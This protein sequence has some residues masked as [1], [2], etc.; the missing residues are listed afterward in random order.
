MR[1]GVDATSWVNRRGYGRFARNVLPRLVALD[2]ET[3]YEFFVDAETA[4]GAGLPDGAGE[5]RIR[6]DRAPTQA[7]TAGSRRSLRDLARLSRAATAAGLDV[8]LFPSV[9]TY[10]PVRSTPTV[11]GIHDTIP[12][13]FPD[14]AVPGRG[15]RTL[16]RLKEWVAVRRAARL[17]TVSEPAR[18]ALARRL[19][20]DGGRIAVVPEAADDVFSPRTAAE[21]AAAAAR[22][23]LAAGERFVLYVGGISPHKDLG[24]LLRAYA[25]VAAGDEAPA[26]LVLAGELETEAYASAAADVRRE[27]RELG[28]GDRVL[29]PGFVPD[30]ALA[31]LYSAAAVVVNP[32]LAEGFGLPAVEAAACGAPTILSDL[33]AHRA[34]LGNAA[35]YFTPRDV[36]GLVSRL[37]QVLNDD[38]LRRS[39]ADRG[40]EAVTGLSW[41]ASAERL[42]GVVAEA[43]ERGR[44]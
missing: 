30:E 11:V 23:G 35:L 16:W 10:F 2:S 34:T 1:V 26:R 19:G 39:L 41:D 24:T 20:I 28:L 7:A 37:A 38:E 43:A 14:L 18:E 31:G 33:P 6:L 32:S 15:A 25:R 21:A 4:A 22:L 5:R 8:F 36:D 40:R 9:Y 27:I 29:L 12:H 3:R 44:A 17:F 13:E 42:R